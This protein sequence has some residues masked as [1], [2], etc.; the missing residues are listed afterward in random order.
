MNNTT[1]CLLIAYH[2]NCPAHDEPS[3]SSEIVR[4]SGGFQNLIEYIRRGMN[5]YKILQVLKLDYLSPSIKVSETY[6]GHHVA[7]I[8]IEFEND[9]DNK[10]MLGPWVLQHKADYFQDNEGNDITP[11]FL[12][13]TMGVYYKAI[14][15][16]DF[17]AEQQCLKTLESYDLKDVAEGRKEYLV[18][19]PGQLVVDV[20]DSFNTANFGMSHHMCLQITCGVLRKYGV[21]ISTPEAFPDELWLRLHEAYAEGDEPQI[22]GN[23]LFLFAT[24]EKAEKFYNIFS[25]YFENRIYAM[26]IGNTGIILNENT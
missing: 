24:Q 20:S 11:D 26:L 15:T 13:A 14:R 10:H 4:I 12:E 23:D 9:F 19:H 22:A 3:P 8:K 7:C 5:E 2:I 18:F 6:E 16:R 21:Y 17:N 25:D 1:H